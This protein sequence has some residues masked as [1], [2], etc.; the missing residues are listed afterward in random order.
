MNY[1]YLSDVPQFSTSYDYVNPQ[2]AA[3]APEQEPLMS[4]DTA[5]AAA[6]GA[7]SGGLSGALMAGGIN[8][9]LT[10]GMAAGGPYAL[11]G[12]AVL[13]MIEAQQRKKAEKEAAEAAQAKQIKDD[14]VNQYNIM[15]KTN[16]G[17]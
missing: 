5:R 11:A 17:V 14:T 15:A 2:T 4:K 12:G 6:Y 10:S 16:F 3:V 7:Q 9:M 13:S 1:S 8:S